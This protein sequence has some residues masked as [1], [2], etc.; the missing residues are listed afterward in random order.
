MHI[1]IKLLFIL[2]FIGITVSAQYPCYNGISTN[3]LNPI[4]NQLTS[5][6]NTF[7][8]WQDS[9]WAM[10]PS[11]FCFRTGFNES[12]FYKIDNLEELREAKDMKWDD[13]WELVRRYV[14]LT[15]TNTYTASNPEHLYVILYNKYTGIL[16]V[17]L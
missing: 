10:Q 1:K 3:P 11:T 15:E 12:P 8:N 2:N 6:K 7:F 17:L 5:K 14:G 13:G 4:N 16:R 9:L